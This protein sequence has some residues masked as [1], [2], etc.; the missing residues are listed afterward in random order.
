L[1]PIQ[2]EIFTSPGCTRCTRVLGVLQG[3]VADLGEDQIQWRKVNVLDE[4][5]HAVQLGVLSMP[6]IAI[7][8]ELVFTV[9]PSPEKFRATLQERLNRRAS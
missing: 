7:D 4:L 8:G 5:D 1:K 9:H 3:I 2:I 6:A